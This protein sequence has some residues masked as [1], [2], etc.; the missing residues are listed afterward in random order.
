MAG[1][2]KQRARREKQQGTSSSEGNSSS[3]PSGVMRES[4][5]RSTPQSI[6]AFDGNRDPQEISYQNPAG[7]NRDPATSA[8]IIDGRR[9]EGLGVSG[10]GVMRG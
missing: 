7:I 6:G 3:Q 8:V 5:P 4:I 9:L 2:A 1:A 10:Y